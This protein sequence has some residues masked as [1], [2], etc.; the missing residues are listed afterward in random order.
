MY[1]KVFTYKSTKYIHYFVSVAQLCELFTKYP[2]LY[3]SFMEL[4]SEHH[5]KKFNIKCNNQNNEVFSIIATLNNTIVVT[6]LSF[7]RIVIKNVHTSQKYRNKGFCKLHLNKVFSLT[8]FKKYRLFVDKE[9][10]IAQKCYKSVGFKKVAVTDRGKLKM[11][12]I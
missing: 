6:I 12:R 1:S 9:N 2:K 4:M 5:S 10:L 8:K 7:K 3:T 11:E